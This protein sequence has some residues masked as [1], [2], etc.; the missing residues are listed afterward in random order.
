MSSRTES[1]S[2]LLFVYDVQKAMFTCVCAFQVYKHEDWQ[3]RLA[4]L[5]LL[6]HVSVTVADGP[7]VEDV[8]HASVQDRALPYVDYPETM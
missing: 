3:Q 1:S 4:E 5:G 6:L 8:V 7:A 2:A